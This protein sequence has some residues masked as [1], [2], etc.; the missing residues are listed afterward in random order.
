[1]YFNLQFH[2]CLFFVIETCF[3]AAFSTLHCI[4]GI[5]DSIQLRKLA[6]DTLLNTAVISAGM[7]EIL[8]KNARL[9]LSSF[10]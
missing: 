7:Y 4:A 1:M 6:S 9:L 3:H 10:E 5:E 8:S 2:N